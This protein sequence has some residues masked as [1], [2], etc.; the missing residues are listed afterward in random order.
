MRVLLVLLLLAGC[1]AD[2]PPLAP[3][4]GSQSIGTISTLPEPL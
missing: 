4:G 2:D 1:G 3:S